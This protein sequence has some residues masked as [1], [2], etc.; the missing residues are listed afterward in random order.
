MLGTWNKPHVKERTPHTVDIHNSI[1]HL[2]ECRAG[3]R[4]IAEALPLPFAEAASSVSMS[5]TA[6]N[7]RPRSVEAGSAASAGLSILERDDDEDGEA[8]NDMAAVRRRFEAP[9]RSNSPK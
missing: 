6:A 8:R 7:C 5:R 9:K 3:E 1:T 4:G 2:A